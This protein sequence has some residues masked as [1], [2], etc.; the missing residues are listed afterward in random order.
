MRISQESD[1]IEILAQPSYTV[2]LVLN[3][4]ESVKETAR[5]VITTEEYE[6]PLYNGSRHGINGTE[7]MN[8][9]CGILV[10]QPRL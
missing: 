5:T 9:L 7:P 10:Q 4:C 2:N 6:P 3:I 8:E 1:S